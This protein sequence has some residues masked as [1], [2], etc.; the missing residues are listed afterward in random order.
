MTISAWL[1]IVQISAKIRNRPFPFSYLQVWQDGDLIIFLM[2]KPALV[3]SLSTTGFQALALRE[4]VEENFKLLHRLGFP[5]AELHVRNPREVDFKSI[6]TKLEQYQ[7]EVPTLGTGQ[8]FFDEGLSLTDPDASV[9]RKARSRLEAHLEISVQLSCFVTIGLI[10]GVP[11]KDKKRQALKML[12]DELFK[13][14]EQVKKIGSPGLILEPLNRYETTIINT[15]SEAK[16]LITEIG[17]SKIGILADSFHMNI[18]EKHIFES[19]KKAGKSIW[20]VHLA[21]S[22]RWPPGSGHFDFDELFR[23]LKKIGYS[24][25]VSGEYMPMPNP[26]SS[27][28]LFARFLKERRLLP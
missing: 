13:L 18:E 20:H 6:Q 12:A 24:A 19:V 10:R 26:D 1:S 3:V 22:N 2:M 17:H 15:L 23:G 16:A 4:K 7:L 21:D 25:W 8:A 11:K 27:V 9:R 5:G 14:C 28:K